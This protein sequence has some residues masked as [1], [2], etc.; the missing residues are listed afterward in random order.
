MNTRKPKKNKKHTRKRYKKRGGAASTNSEIDDISKSIIKL[1]DNWYCT[2][3]G[4][5][6]RTM[7]GILQILS[8]AKYEI[9]P[10]INGLNIHNYKTID[11]YYRVKGEHFLLGIRAPGHY[12]YIETHNSNIRIISLWSELH[13]IYDYYNRGPYGKLQRL[14]KQFIDSFNKL[15]SKNDEQIEEALLELFG[16]VDKNK[17]SVNVKNLKLD[18]YKLNPVVDYNS[19]KTEL[20][21]SNSNQN[22]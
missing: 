1:K 8:D 11:E 3:S 13:G 7:E 14:T 20:Y 10:I 5:C 21:N 4:E 16:E 22:M 17:Y 6:H 9:K 2:N 18:V 15:C 12:F 19:N